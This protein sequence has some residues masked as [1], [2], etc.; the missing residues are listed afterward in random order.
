MSAPSE[1]KWWC[2]LCHLLTDEAFC[3][4]VNGGFSRGITCRKGKSIT[5]ISIYSSKNKTL[6]FPWRKMK[7]NLE[8]K[9][10]RFMLG[11]FVCLVFVFQDRVPPCSP[12]W[13]GIHSVDHAGLELTYPPASASWMYG[14]KVC[15]TTARQDFF[16]YSYSFGT[17]IEMLE[18]LCYYHLL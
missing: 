17:R 11:H 1:Q 13:P 3:Q 9:K 12:D 6:S 4:S 14:L 2:Y 8:E 16:M 7:A 5:R 10:W 15:A 18:I